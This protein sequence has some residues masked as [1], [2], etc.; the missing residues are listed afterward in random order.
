MPNLVEIGLDARA[1]KKEDTQLL[2]LNIELFEEPIY[3]TVYIDV[4]QDIENFDDDHF[5]GLIDELVLEVGPF[6]PLNNYTFLERLV[7]L[8]RLKLVGD[9][10]PTPWF[11]DIR[12]GRWRTLG[13][14][15]TI[16]FLDLTGSTANFESYEWFPKAVKELVCNQSFLVAPTT[17]PAYLSKLSKIQ[18][19]TIHFF[20]NEIGGRTVKFPAVEHI[21]LKENSNCARVPV[22]WLSDFLA[23]CNDL[24]I[25]ETDWLSVLDI[26]ACYASFRRLQKLIVYNPLLTTVDKFVKSPVKESE[27]VKLPINCLFEGYR[28]FHSVQCCIG[29]NELI[30]Y[31]ALREFC[32]ESLTLERIEIHV[33]WPRISELYYDTHSK[34][35]SSSR[36]ERRASRNL[37]IP[38]KINPPQ[39]TY[40]LPKKM[41]EKTLIESLFFGLSDVTYQ[42]DS[43]P[44]NSFCTFAPDIRSIIRDEKERLGYTGYLLD[45]Y[46]RILTN[47]SGYEGILVIDVVKFKSLKSR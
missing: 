36:K 37:P 6:S 33:T 42:L 11:S 30:S 25:L 13:E 17:A 40:Y 21:V 38:E 15:T 29:V 8:Q 2:A 22:D 18:K 3:F 41:K 34:M 20:T 32:Q 43:F 28:N 31:K 10:C 46:G 5:I 35:A 47:P 27:L 45:D 24:I 16:K 19:L 44:V 14:L 9:T 26:R 7:N 12:V 39:G 1:L 23:S 4:M